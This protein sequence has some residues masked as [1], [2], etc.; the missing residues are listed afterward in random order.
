MPPA[1]TSPPTNVVL[2]AARDQQADWR[3]AAEHVRVALACWRHAPSGLRQAAFD[4]Y[5]RALDAEEQA[6]KVYGE[7]LREAR[8]S[9]PRAGRG[10]RRRLG[11]RR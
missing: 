6:A 10:E 5:R 1:P 3:G 2:D 9:A 4:E 8:T 11:R 7:L